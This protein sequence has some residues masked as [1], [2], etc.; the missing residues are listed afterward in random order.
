MAEDNRPSPSIHL[1]LTPSA[2][3]SGDIT[4]LDSK[5]TLKR[6]SFQS[7]D[8][9]CSFS[10][11]GVPRDHPTWYPYYEPHDTL[12]NF[13][14]AR[15]RLAVTLVHE[16]SH[17]VCLDQD[18]Q[19]DI[20]AEWKVPAF[21]AGGDNPGERLGTASTLRRDQGGVI[22]AG[23]YFLPRFNVGRERQCQVVVEWDLLDCPKG[24]R[25]VCSLGEGLEPVTVQGTRDT[26]L[27]CV[28][29]VGPVNSHPPEPPPRASKDGGFCGTY[30]FGDLPASLSAVRDYPSE[31]FPRMAE[32]FRDQKGSYR[33]F[34]RRV[35]R[36]P[37]L[38]STVFLSSSIMEYDDAEGR[39][40]HDWDLVRLLNRAMV[41]AWTRLDAEDDGAENDWFTD[42]LSLLYTVFLPFRLGQRGPDYFRATIN[43][44]LSAYYTNPLV[45]EPSAVL[46]GLVSGHGLVRHCWYAA[47]ARA[48]RAFVYMLKMDFLTRRAAVARGAD[49]LR[50]MDELVR[51]LLV[52][53]RDGGAGGK[54]RKRDWLAGV[55][56]WLEDED[57]DRHFKE[58]IEN[59]QGSVNGLE[60]L[61]SSFGK[62]H[63]PH[64]VE[65]EMLEF[66]FDRKSLEDGSVSGIVVGSKAW[67]A[68]LRDGDRIAWY[69]RPEAC[70]MDIDN[71]KTFRLAVER[72]G[73]KVNME[74]RPRSREKVRCW[75]VLEGKYEPPTG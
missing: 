12:P 48:T 74:Y 23:R 32:H 38:T 31:I 4:S 47:S 68:G 56:Y 19:G 66:G 71:N 75:Q 51:D 40:A 1:R 64:P 6:F 9:L 49:V 65:H 44:F 73:E 22:G 60:D 7:G 45:A 37:R 30:W 11:Q 72:N 57:A 3:D 61:L 54:V 43:A 58:M 21:E 67:E 25:A 28:F 24:T 46:D 59:K 50:P 13:S 33:A 36:G 70:E 42:G 14:D 10:R 34:L 41:S 63:G 18:T 62:K 17:Q 5:A 55:A 29:M 52:R 20:I 39:D 27:D 8:I 53:R 15:G 35:P 16:N 26:L 69:L 2:D